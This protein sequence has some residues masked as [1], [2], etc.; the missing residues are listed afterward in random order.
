[1][2]NASLSQNEAKNK[3]LLA[4]WRFSGSLVLRQLRQVLRTAS[5]PASM[6]GSIHR[7]QY[8]L[9]MRPGEFP[10]P[11]MVGVRV[12]VLS[13]GNSGSVHH[14]ELHEILGKE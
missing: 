6:A 12:A 14:H 3:A 8:S 11:L 1:M 9:S 10:R 13:L 4:V 7:M 2:G 5:C